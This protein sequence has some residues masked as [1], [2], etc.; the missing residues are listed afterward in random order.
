MPLESII[1][2]IIA[3]IV[4]TYGLLV[5]ALW[6]GGLGLPR[7]DFSRAM[8]ELTYGES[9][10]GQAPYW[11]GQAVIYLNGIFFALIYATV[12][13]KYLPGPDLLRGA[14]WGAIL[15]FVSGVFFVPLFLKEG[16]FLSH[17]HKNAWATSAMVHGVWGMIV[18]WLSPIH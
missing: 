2:T 14:I 11:A 7:L 15:W 6:A 18:G 10:E 1:V 13:G 12:V 3:G 9:F 16:F 17:I 8:A 4:A 5:M